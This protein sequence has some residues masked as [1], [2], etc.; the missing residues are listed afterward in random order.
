MLQSVEK[1]KKKNPKN[2]KTNKPTINKKI[3]VP[4]EVKTIYD[5]YLL[6]AKL[7]VNLECINIL[8]HVNITG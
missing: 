1:S 7:Y 2:P 3:K 5:V 8:T 6:E 4:I